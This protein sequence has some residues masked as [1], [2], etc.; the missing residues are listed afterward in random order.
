MGGT[1]AVTIIYIYEIS[2]DKLHGALGLAIQIL[3]VIGIL[4]AVTIGS[5]VEWDQL[6]LVFIVLL[7][8]YVIGKSSHDTPINYFALSSLFLSNSYRTHDIH[9]KKQFQLLQATPTIYFLLGTAGD[10]L[11]I[12]P[13]E[14]K[15]FG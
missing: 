9:N 12:Y 4:L 5:C 6:A 1:S 2:K 15:G 8:P 14:N 13:L 11:I 7:I 10:M 3:V